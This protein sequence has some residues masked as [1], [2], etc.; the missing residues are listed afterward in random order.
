[1]DP[2]VSSTEFLFVSSRPARNEYLTV[3]TVGTISPSREPFMNEWTNLF[4]Q[5]TIT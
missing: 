1:M 5:E 3:S 2:P 4:Q